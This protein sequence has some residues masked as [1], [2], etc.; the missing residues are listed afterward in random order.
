MK[1]FYQQY[2]DKTSEMKQTNFQEKKQKPGQ[3]KNIKF[4][5]KYQRTT[6]KEYQK[7]ILK[8]GKP[9]KSILNVKCL[10][11]YLSDWQ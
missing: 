3:S 5:L 6:N 7:Q 4:Q 8:R 2:Y 10:D 1:L 11:A 9:I